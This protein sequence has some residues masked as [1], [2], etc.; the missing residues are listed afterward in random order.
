MNKF[1][2][3]LSF[4]IL[5]FCSCQ[6][7]ANH[8]NH[9]LIVGTNAEFAPFTFIDDGE[10]VGFEIDMAREVCRRLGYEMQLVDLPFDSLIP[11]IT[12]GAVH[13]V[14]AGMTVTE[15]RAKKVCFT[16][17]YLSEDPL[18]MVSLS[19]LNIQNLE[20]L[21]QYNVVVNEGYTADLFL[22]EKLNTPLMRLP[23]PVDG[24]LALQSGRADLFVTA[25]N[26][27]KPFLSTYHSLF[28]VPI[29]ESSENCAMMVSKEYPQLLESLNVVLQNM[30][31]DGN[32]D[33]LKEKW[34][35][36]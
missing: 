6:R 19:N 1:S 35:I 24:F 15:E 27:L 17:P 2:F 22:S 13:F 11:E 12:T 23:H 32:V 16:I 25:R 26:T 34:G 14:A 5:V 28:V 30:I 7:S 36:Q 21:K 29:E 8:A 3:L 31:A 10:I 18:V 9:R 33:L 20:D 4:C